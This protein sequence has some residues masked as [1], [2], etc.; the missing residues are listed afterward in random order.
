MIRYIALSVMLLPGIAHA[1]KF[2]SAT[3]S[4]DATVVEPAV[5]Q[6][7]DSFTV[8]STETA[9]GDPVQTASLEEP[10]DPAADYGDSVV[11]NSTTDL[12]LPDFVVQ[13]NVSGS[14]SIDGNTL[15][16]RV[17]IDSEGESTLALATAGSSAE[18]YDESTATSD[19]ANFEVGECN[20]GTDWASN[21]AN[22]WN[23][24]PTAVD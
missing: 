10:V 3:D 2:V 17:E 21:D 22:C 14:T 11:I 5:E 19:A 16:A 8:A 13:T 6:P 15:I 4:T 20:A 9:E 24:Y 7:A 18:I 1:Q 12:E 23:S